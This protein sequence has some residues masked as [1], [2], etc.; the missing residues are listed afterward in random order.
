MKGQAKAVTLRSM[1]CSNGQLSVQSCWSGYSGGR[2][3]T[4]ADFSHLQPSPDWHPKLATLLTWRVAHKNFS[5]CPCRHLPILLTCLVP[6]VPFPACRCRC[7]PMLFPWLVPSMH[8]P[9]CPGCRLPQVG[10]GGAGVGGVQ[11][12]DGAG[13]YPT[14]GC[15]GGVTRR[16][17][18]T[19]VGQGGIAATLKGVLAVG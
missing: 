5:A 3:S 1:F 18:A 19:Q 11:Q 16:G 15:H 4:K 7:V 10:G 17:G 2:E 14:A 13:D 12:R 9:A 8:F 6:L